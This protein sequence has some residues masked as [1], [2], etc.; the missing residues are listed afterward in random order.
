MVRVIHSMLARIDFSM[1]ASSN[2][3]VPAGTNSRCSDGMPS[4]WP[5]SMIGFFFASRAISMSV[6]KAMCVSQGA[7]CAICDVI[8]GG[9]R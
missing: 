2:S 8:P 3:S 5:I 1:I 4:F 9:T 6:L 7:N